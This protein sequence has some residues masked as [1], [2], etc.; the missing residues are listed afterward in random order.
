MGGFCKNGNE[1]SVTLNLELMLD[2]NAAEPL[3]V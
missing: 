2:E 3:R 1:P